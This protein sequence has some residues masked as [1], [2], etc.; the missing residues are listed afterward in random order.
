MSDQSVKTRPSRE[1]RR[2][3]LI[4]AAFGLFIKSG[5]AATRLEDVAAL[6]GVAKG[7]VV[8]HF[9]T[10]EVL[11]AAVITHYVEPSVARAEAITG[12]PGTARERLIHL[13][14]FIHGQLCDPHIGGIPKL[15]VSEAG[16]FP[17]LARN[18]HEQVCSRSRLAESELIRQGIAAGEFRPVDA[19]LAARL[20]LDPIIMHAIWKHSL[21]RYEPTPVCSDTY[22]ATHLDVF[23]RGIAAEH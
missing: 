14:H 15:I 10:K 3:E 20:L 9:P 18:F 12:E 7:T 16:N 8:V 1:A 21:G 17:E 2:E 13:A 4:S 23:L 22:L 11:F 19:D 6:A 5:F